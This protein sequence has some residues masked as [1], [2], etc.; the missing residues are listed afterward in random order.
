MTWTDAKQLAD[1]WCAAQLP[2]DLRGRVLQ[3]PDFAD[4]RTAQHYY[5]DRNQAYH[6]MVLN[7]ISRIVRKRGGKMTYI[8]V[9]IAHQPASSTAEA[10][11]A[12]CWRLL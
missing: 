5:G 4:D 8:I 7:A 1:Q 10:F 12:S 2:A 11:I 9:E 6:R 3:A